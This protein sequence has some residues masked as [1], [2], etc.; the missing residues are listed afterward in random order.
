MGDAAGERVRLLGEREPRRAASPLEPGERAVAWHR[1]APAHL[2]LERLR[3]VRRLALR[4]PQER[5]AVRLVSYV[6]RRA[7]CGRLLGMRAFVEQDPM[8]LILSKRSASKDA[9]S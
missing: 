9:R 1:R 6:L 4:Q 8:L 7:R 3:R 5:A 2:D